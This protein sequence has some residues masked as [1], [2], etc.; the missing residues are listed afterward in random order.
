MDY[1]LFMLEKVFFE[2]FLVSEIKGS[3]GSGAR[4]LADQ[5]RR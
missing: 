2:S 1:M 5:E 3:G 4:K